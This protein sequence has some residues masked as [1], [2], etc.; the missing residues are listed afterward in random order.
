MGRFE[1]QGGPNR[2]RRGMQETEMDG[3]EA[4]GEGT[5]H[6][7]GGCCGEGGSADHRAGRE[8]PRTMGMMGRGGGPT[9]VMRERMA[10]MY[11]G[12]QEEDG[13][14]RHAGL[15]AG[16]AMSEAMNACIDALQRIGRGD[17]P[18]GAGEVPGLRRAFGDW[19]AKV[20]AEAEAALSGGEAEVAEVAAAL[21]VGEESALFVLARL[22]AEGRVTLVAR[23][24]TRS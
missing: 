17:L 16:L 20:E 18:P 10:R 14:G 21:G 4:H 9:A 15:E 5:G 24:R 3:R 7:G 13:E 19:L 2:R 22:A 1:G 11:D 8:S 23:R 12:E 6:E